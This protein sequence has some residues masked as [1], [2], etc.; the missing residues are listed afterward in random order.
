M[1]RYEL[2]VK[3]SVEAASAL[4]LPDAEAVLLFQSVRELLI[5][6]SKHSGTRE[7][8]VSSHISHG[9]LIT[10]V[11]DAGI[12]FDVAAIATATAS[13]IPTGGLSSK[14][15]LF[16][17]QERMRAVGGAFDIESTPERGT[18]ARLVLPIKET[19]LNSLKAAPLFT[20]QDDSSI[21]PPSSLEPRYA[22][23]RFVKPSIKV[24]LVDDHAMVRQGIR[25]ILSDYPDIEI[26]GEANDGIEALCSVEQHRPAVVMM[27]INMPNMDGI[28]ATA[29]IKERYPHIQIIG[30]SVNA[31]SDNQEAMQSR[32]A[33]VLLSKESAAEALHDAIMKTAKSDKTIQGSTTLKGQQSVSF[34][35]P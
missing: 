34:I 28:E 4:D 20:K 22:Q 8:W 3:V 11:K 16:S 23:N 2:E 30:L 13:A 29:R 6:V 17:I 15:G 19:S 12:G 35:D 25:S 5:N 10:E 14:F 26:V 1:K 21:I 24:L 9:E 31:G 33:A 32:G 7:A 18:T 27:D